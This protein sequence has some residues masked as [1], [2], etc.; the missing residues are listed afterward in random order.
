MAEAISLCRAPAT[1]ATEGAAATVMLDER[2]SEAA[3]NCLSGWVHEHP[4]AGFAKLGFVGSER[5]KIR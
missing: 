1:V 4:E 5:L 2:R 3:F